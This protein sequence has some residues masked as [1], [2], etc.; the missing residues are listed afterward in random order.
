MNIAFDEIIRNGV[1]ALPEHLKKQAE[2]RAAHVVITEAERPDDSEEGGWDDIIKK[3]V[4]NPLP[5]FK[6]LSRDEANDRRL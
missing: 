6:P 3:L 4:A 1:I 2:G 5:S